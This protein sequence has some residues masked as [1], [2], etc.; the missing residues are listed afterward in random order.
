MVNVNL[1]NNYNSQKL[2]NFLETFRW[3]KLKLKSEEQ[4]E[5]S[6]NNMNDVP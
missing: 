1:V 2:W 6:N 4:F 5:I 3:N